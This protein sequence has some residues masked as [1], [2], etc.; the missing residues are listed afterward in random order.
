VVGLVT[1]EDQRAL[2]SVVLH[3]VADGLDA[4]GWLAIGLFAVVFI[5]AIGVVFAALEAAS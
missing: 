3:A 2:A 4:W 5:V 1:P